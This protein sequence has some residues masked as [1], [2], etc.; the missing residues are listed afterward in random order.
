MRLPIGMRPGRRPLVR[1]ADSSSST[2]LPAGGIWSI[3]VAPA[4]TCWRRG[5]STVPLLS[6]TAAESDDCGTTHKGGPPVHRTRW[7][8]RHWP[9]Y[10]APTR[11]NGDNGAGRLHLQAVL[12]WA[13]TNGFEVSDRGQMAKNLQGGV[14][15][16]A[17][18]RCGVAGAAIIGPSDASS[19]AAQCRLNRLA[20]QFPSNTYAVGANPKVPG[21]LTVNPHL[22]GS[23]IHGVALDAVGL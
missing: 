11:R 9:A 22:S 3:L 16:G 6:T 12:D 4:P 5:P 19:I 20:Y 17:L 10:T 15:T 23:R 13:R 1:S 8:R 2:A 21:L 18:T 7:G 14:R